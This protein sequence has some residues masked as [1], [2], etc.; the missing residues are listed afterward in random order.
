MAQK[1]IL[2]E[3]NRRKSIRATAQALQISDYTVHKVLV[4]YGVINTILTNR[5]SE[6][7]RIGMN[8]KQIAEMLSISVSSVNR[9]TSYE[10]GLYLNPSMTSNAVYMRK[11]RVKRKT[12]PDSD[13]VE[14]TDA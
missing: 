14:K 2:A 10:R 12:S 5:I 11:Y 13:S 9:N 1:E 7:R 8:Q 3:Y 6:L 4:G